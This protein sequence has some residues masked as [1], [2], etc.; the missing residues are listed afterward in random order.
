MAMIPAEVT[1]YQY[2]YRCLR[3]FD[4]EDGYC[5]CELRVRQREFEINIYCENS[6]T[7]ADLPNLKFNLGIAALKIIEKVK[8][9]RFR[10]IKTENTILPG[11]SKDICLSFIGETECSDLELPDLKLNLSDLAE[12]IKES[13][14][15]DY[16]LKIADTEITLN[17]DE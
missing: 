6:C 9:E 2:C 13:L 1:V 10:K 4:A 12:S 16:R 15:E 11:K 14:K 7:E 5:D 3:Y 8:D 17:P